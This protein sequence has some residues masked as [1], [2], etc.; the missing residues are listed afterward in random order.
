MQG[1]AL[2]ADMKAATAAFWQVMQLQ[3]AVVE[4]LT[5]QNED[6]ARGGSPH[7]LPTAANAHKLAPAPI[8]VTLPSPLG[9]V[10]VGLRLYAVTMPCQC[11]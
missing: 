4:D 9:N 7:S 6:V 5:R 11:S 2:E 10:S 8:Q 1:G 3:A